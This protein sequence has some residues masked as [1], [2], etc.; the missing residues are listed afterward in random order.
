MIDD[1]ARKHNSQLFPAANKLGKSVQYNT[2]ITIH[3]LN[4]HCT[5]YK[6]CMTYDMILYWHVQKNI[7]NMQYTIRTVVWRHHSPYCYQL[8]T[9]EKPHIYLVSKMHDTFIECY[10]LP[11]CHQGESISYLH[12]SFLLTLLRDCTRIHRILVLLVWYL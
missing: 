12:K 9:V 4:D 5:T 6:T 2:Q 11:Y 8:K 10:F 7:Y 1:P 3:N